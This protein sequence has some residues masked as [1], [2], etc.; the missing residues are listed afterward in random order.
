MNT[1]INFTKLNELNTEIIEWLRE[2]ENKI[3]TEIAIAFHVNLK[4][5]EDCKRINIQYTDFNKVDYFVYVD[6][7]K[8]GVMFFT[9]P[10]SSWNSSITINFKWLVDTPLA[11]KI[12]KDANGE[13]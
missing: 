4:S 1:E 12:A 6:G 13:K 5:K 8:V 7:I 11:A 2:Q 3:L 10:T 9:L